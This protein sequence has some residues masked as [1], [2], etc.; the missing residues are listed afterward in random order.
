[1]CLYHR[2]LIGFK[3]SWSSLINF[4]TVKVHVNVLRKNI[5]FFTY[6]IY[7]SFHNFWRLFGGHFVRFNWHIR[8]QKKFQK[9]ERNWVIF[10]YQITNLLNKKAHAK[11]SKLYSTSWASTLSQILLSSLEHNVFIIFIKPYIICLGVYVA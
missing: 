8:E 4:K 11:I 1:M 3:C 6:F 9:Q 5:F 10:Q 2:N 7:K